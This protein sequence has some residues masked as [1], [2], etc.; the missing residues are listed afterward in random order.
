LSLLLLSCSHKPRPLTKEYNRTEWIHWSDIDNDCQDTR[1]EILISRSLVKPTLDRSGCRVIEGKWHDYY[2]PELH[3]K[4]K[5]VDIDHLIPL[6]HAHDVGGH[7]WSKEEKEKFAND[8][9]N[10][11]ITKSS[12]NRKKGA[13]RIDQWLPVHH[14]Y[15]CKYIRDWIKLKQKYKLKITSPEQQTI[16]TSQCKIQY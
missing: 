11:V 3:V 12:Y 16:K 13:K 8:H 6:K 4:A 2:Y 15:S 14:D 5:S 9:D 1:H 10:L 7:S